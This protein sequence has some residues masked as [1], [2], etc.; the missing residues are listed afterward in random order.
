MLIHRNYI[1]KKIWWDKKQAHLE[2][3]NKENYNSSVSVRVK[4]STNLFVFELKVRDRILCCN[5]KVA[6]FDPKLVLLHPG[7][8]L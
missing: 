4:S 2:K 7:G 6:M 8:K 1:S 5:Y 3:V